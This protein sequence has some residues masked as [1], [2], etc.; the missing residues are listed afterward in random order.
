MLIPRGIAIPLGNNASNLTPILMAWL[1]LR[2][3][4][5]KMLEARLDMWKNIAAN[6]RER[7]GKPKDAEQPGDA[8]KPDIG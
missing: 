7:K 3:V 4:R 6:A 1:D 2:E 8:G 5:R